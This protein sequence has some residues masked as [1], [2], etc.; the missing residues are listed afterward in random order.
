M[1]PPFLLD[2]KREILFSST[3]VS[4]REGGSR[5]APDRSTKEMGVVSIRFFTF[6]GGWRTRLFLI[7]FAETEGAGFAEAFGD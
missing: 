4:S 3:K 2:R 1:T 5:F 6:G 7:G